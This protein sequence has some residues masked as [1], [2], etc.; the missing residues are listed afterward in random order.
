MLE[1]RIQKNLEKLRNSQNEK[2]YSYLCNKFY[3]VEG[4]TEEGVIPTNINIKGGL[5]FS[6]LIPDRIE[7]FETKELVPMTKQIAA[8]AFFS[9]LNLAAQ[10]IVEL[11]VS[12]PTQ[13]QLT[14]ATFHIII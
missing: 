11:K 5:P 7:D 13:V 9:L 14:L 4:C 12:E 8:N 1:S 6:Y 10:D 2:F 3:E